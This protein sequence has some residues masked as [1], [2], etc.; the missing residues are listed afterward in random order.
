MAEWPFED[1]K[2]LIFVA[3]HPDDL[4]TI[5]GGTIYRMAQKGVEII[6]VLC[7]DGNIGTH[8]TEK[9]TRQSL[10]RVRRREARA[11]AQF[12]GVREVAF[13]GYDDGE[14]VPSLE[15]RAELARQYRIYQPDTLMTFDPYVEGHPDHRGCGKLAVVAEPVEDTLVEEALGRFETLE[16][17]QREIVLAALGE[18]GGSASLRSAWPDLDPAQRNASMKVRLESATV[19]AGRAGGEF[20]PG[21][22]KPIWRL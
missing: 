18:T 1:V 22:V 8:E 14:L 16:P 15:V 6:E 5:A 4:E 20:D 9:Y 10:A 7:T 11:A 17:A 21:R 12:L 13:L 3:A 2:R 19:E